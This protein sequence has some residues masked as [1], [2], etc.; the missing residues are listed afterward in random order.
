MSTPHARNIVRRLLAVNKTMR[1]Q[2]LYAQGLSE[3]PATPFPHPPPP[4]QYPA[5]GGGLKPAPP[6]PPNPG[7]P[8]KSHAYLKHKVIP[9]LISTGE[10]EK[11]HSV[12]PLTPGL[13][14]SKKRM[15]RTKNAIASGG[16]DIWQWR[17]AGI[18]A[19]APEPKLE[20]EPIPDS[21]DW[22]LPN[23]LFPVIEK[24]KKQ[25]ERDHYG[26]GRYDHLNTRRQNA[27]PEKLRREKEWVILV[28]GV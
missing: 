26:A 2:D 18:Q 23:R 27:R 11:V 3:Y 19:N 7:H 20:E 13:G 24:A 25:K 16:V 21:H 5:R 6:P 9:E 4:K 12:V 1:V 15:T 17:L 14:S 22:Y 10:I 8:F 28:F